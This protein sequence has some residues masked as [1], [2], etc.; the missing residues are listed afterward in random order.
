MTDPVER[1]VQAFNA[2]DLEAFLEPYAADTR[3]EDGSGEEIM[4]GLEEMRQFYG[5]LFANSPDLHCDV[6]HRI[7]LGSWVIDEEKVEGAHAE[8]FPE[9]IYAAVAYR[10]GNGQITFVRMF[11]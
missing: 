7:S 9:Q 6:L 4:S 10:V 11:M 8:G 5:D 2:R 3:V 1:Q